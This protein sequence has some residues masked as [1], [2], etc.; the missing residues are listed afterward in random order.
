MNIHGA[1]ATY[2][3][4]VG[5]RAIVRD[6]DATLPNPTVSTPVDLVNATTGVVVFFGNLSSGIPTLEWRGR[7]VWNEG[8]GI[9]VS[10]G[11]SVDVGITV[12]GYLLTLP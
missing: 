6:L 3:V 5:F 2:T 10:A 4:P 7:Q 12:S 8:E 9:E 11:G 1:N